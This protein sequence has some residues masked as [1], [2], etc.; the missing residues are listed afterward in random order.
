M[1]VQIQ[2]DAGRRGRKMLNS[3]RDNNEGTYRVVWRG[4]RGPLCDPESD[5]LLGG[6][7]VVVRG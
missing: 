6:S 5:I 1:R 7:T 4:E 2:F 3:S